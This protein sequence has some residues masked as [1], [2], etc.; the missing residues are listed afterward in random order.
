MEIVA[1]VVDGYASREFRG[2]TVHRRRI[3][4]NDAFETWPLIL[5]F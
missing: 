4:S 5:W 3:S 2:F 1:V